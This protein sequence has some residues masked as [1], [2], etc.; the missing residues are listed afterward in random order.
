MAFLRI[1]KK[2]S[3]LSRNFSLFS[4]K[5]TQD[6][7]K[8]FQ[9]EEQK[10]EEEE[11][12]KN[13]IYGK[14]FYEESKTKFKEWFPGETFDPKDCLKVQHTDVF[15]DADQYYNVKA[16]WRKDLPD[17]ELDFIKYNPDTKEY[18]IQKIKGREY[19]K[20][21]R[22]IFVGIVGAFVPE[23][24]EQVVWDWATRSKGIKK[25]ARMD[26]IIIVSMNDAYVM[27]HFAKKLDY[28]DRLSFIADW[29]GAFTKN[30]ETLIEFD[31]GCGLGARSQRYSSP[32]IHGR[33][34]A[35]YQSA[36]GDKLLYTVS[37]HPIY[38]WRLLGNWKGRER[39]YL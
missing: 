23:C 11:K 4:D 9:S 34:K 3:L 19:F 2:S 32:T 33:M 14:R 37:S 25:S 26:E 20:Q 27:Q 17:T 5:R 15:D 31:S 8:I 10:N 13:K 6:H 38:L 39:I 1:L 30:A 22:V 16:T 36:H 29:N 24:T 12:K 21:Q 7:K 35:I 28:G 18:E